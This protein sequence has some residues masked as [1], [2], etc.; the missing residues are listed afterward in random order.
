MQLAPPARSTR[1]R[2]HSHLLRLPGPPALQPFPPPGTLAPP[3][4]AVPAAGGA[5]ATAE[6]GRRLG[7]G[8]WRRLQPLPSAP[9]V[10]ERRFPAVTGLAGG[11]P[12]RVLAGREWPGGV[13]ARVGQGGPRPRARP[14]CLVL[15]GTC[16]R[17]SV[18]LC[19]AHPRFRFIV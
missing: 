13:G 1:L 17:C 18:D 2:G 12:Q 4:S 10:S 7:W 3:G 6:P 8:D 9:R 11:R 19:R 16:V 15:S 5:A 14:G